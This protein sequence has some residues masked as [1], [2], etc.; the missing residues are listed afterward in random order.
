[1]IHLGYLMFR[2]HMSSSCIEAQVPVEC[3]ELKARNH[4]LSLAVAP[5]HDTLVETAESTPCEL[6]MILYELLIAAMSGKWLLFHA[7]FCYLRL[8]LPF[9]NT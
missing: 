2:S 5:G 3:V 6:A 1:M 8:F 9:P 7:T 4:D